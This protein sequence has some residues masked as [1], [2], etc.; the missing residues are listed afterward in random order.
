MLTRTS[1][2]ED[3]ANAVLYEGY[4]LYPYR[5]SAVK[6][7]Q[8]WNFGVLYP[9]RYAAAQSGAD[10]D[11][12]RTECLCRGA[13]LNV[14]VRFLQLVRRDTLDLDGRLLQSWQE[15]VEREVSLSASLASADACA[16]RRR[17]R[18]PQA[19]EP[20]AVRDESGAATREIL[21]VR[22]TVEGIVT[23]RAEPA[24]GWLRI[25]VTVANTSPAGGGGR[26]EALMRSAVS[27]HTILTVEDGE[28][29]SLLDPPAGLKT[30]A[31]LCRNRGTWPV[32]AGD[33]GARDTMLSSPIILYDFPQVAPESAGPLFDG[34]EIDEILSL[35]ILAMTDEE[36][37][38]M[39]GVD[40]QARH[41]LDRTESL[42]P[43][44]F[45]RLH[46]TLRGGPGEEP[47]P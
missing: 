43:E 1:R 27:V 7:R 5:A 47:A 6:N 25:R 16:A 11:S 24:G 12:M 29:V 19:A 9:P 30:E 22:E 42:T 20:E 40:A 37:R 18:F 33:E 3:I 32:L 21:R 35:R 31:E 15:A 2:V 34:T 28:F 39:R 13:R 14:R 26:D 44:Q 36:K 10:S 38:E 45:L 41:I 4:L 17:F 46:G 8:R 23:L